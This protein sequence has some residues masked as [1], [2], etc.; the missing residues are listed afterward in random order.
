MFNDLE[1]VLGFASVLTHIV[2]NNGDVYNLDDAKDGLVAI[3]KHAVHLTDDQLDAGAEEFR[4]MFDK[5]DALV[6]AE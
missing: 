1:V 2:T 4:K 6:N 3:T 5:L